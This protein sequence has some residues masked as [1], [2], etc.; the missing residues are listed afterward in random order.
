MSPSGVG[1]TVEPGT[2]LVSMKKFDKIGE[3]NETDKTVTA[4]T[5]VLIEDLLKRLEET[6]LTLANQP[7]TTGEMHT[8]II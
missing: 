3:I 4:E 6:N 8:E 1:L 5:G 2:V 7:A